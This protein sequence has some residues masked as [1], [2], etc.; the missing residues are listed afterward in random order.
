MLTSDLHVDI[1]LETNVL[2]LS[3]DEIRV[4]FAHDCLSAAFTTQHT[5]LM[6]IQPEGLFQK[7]KIFLSLK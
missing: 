2:V 3:R 1:F 7:G 6:R 4:F 5:M